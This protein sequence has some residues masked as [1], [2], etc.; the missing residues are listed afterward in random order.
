MKLDLKL[1]RLIRRKFSQF[2]AFMPHAHSQDA[3]PPFTIMRKL[4]HMYGRMVKGEL[5]GIDIKRKY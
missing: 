4:A 2:T 1:I 5:I 3:R